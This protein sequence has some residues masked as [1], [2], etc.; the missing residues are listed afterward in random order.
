[1][2]KKERIVRASGEAIA[3]RLARGED[4]TDWKR[5]KAM[6]QAEVERL[7]DEEEGKLPKGWEAR[8]V[9]GIPAPKKDI[10]IRLD[11]DIVDWFRS[12]GKG[13]QTRINAVLRAFVQ[14]R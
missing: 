6:S 4:R 2:A 8:I 14:S 12:R 9:L 13:Y 3:R 10:H 5:V 1:M 11:A 7:A